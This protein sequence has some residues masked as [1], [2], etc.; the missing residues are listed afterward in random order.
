MG[1]IHIV[2]DPRNIVTSFSHHFQQTPQ[3]SLESLLSHQYLGEKSEKHALTYVGSW[4]YHYNSW[5]VF[6]NYKEIFWPH[7]ARRIIGD[8]GN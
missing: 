7:C 8:R 3:Q 6:E 5:K 2:R 4:K 1:V